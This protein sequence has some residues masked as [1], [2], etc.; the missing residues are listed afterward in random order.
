MFHEGCSTIRPV[1]AMHNG[2]FE[3]KHAR[4]QALLRQ[5]GGVSGFWSARACALSRKWLRSPSMAVKTGTPA[6]YMEMDMALLPGA[7][8][9]KLGMHGQ[10]G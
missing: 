7:G 4:R 1:V 3:L 5:R 10:M 2:V 8:M 6:E 9:Y